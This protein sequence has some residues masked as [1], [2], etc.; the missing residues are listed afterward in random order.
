MIY[1]LGDRVPTLGT[2]S[3]VAPN[4]TVIGSVVL[5]DR[6]SIWFGAVIRGD[7]DLITI[8]ADSNIQEMSVLHTDP[9]LRLTIGRGVT[10]GH[11][12]TIH[13][14]T[15]GDHSL[16][17]IQSVVMNRAKIGRFCIIGAGALVTEGKEIPDYSVVMGSPGKV[18][19]TLTPDDEPMLHALAANYVA[20][21]RRFRNDLV[22]IG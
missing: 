6:A 2:D 15:I 11:Q 5:E 19:K 3:W 16:I 1:R 12:A 13:G 9:G 7:N 18:V 4:A 20:N 8:G 14:C 17:G 22:P 21:A 10:V